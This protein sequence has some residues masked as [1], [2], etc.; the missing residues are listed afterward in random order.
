MNTIT[1]QRI[2]GTLRLSKHRPNAANASP[3]AH[4]N[5]SDAV[6]DSPSDAPRDTPNDARL[7]LPHDRDENVGMTGGVSSPLVEQAAR[8]LKRGIKDTSRG[9]E[10]NVAY[11]KLKTP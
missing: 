1:R 3:S 6:T 9:A 10:A 2:V 11:Q 4:I 5:L 8:D 7:D